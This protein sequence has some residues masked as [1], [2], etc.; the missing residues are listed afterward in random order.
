MNRGRW[1][2]ECPREDCTWAYRATTD[3]GKPHRFLRCT[4]DHLGKGCDLPFAVAW[5]PLDVCLEV[6]RVLFK[7]RQRLTQNWQ[8][9]RE[10]VDAL[11]QENEQLLV[12]WNL[13]RLAEAGIGVAC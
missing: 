11:I 2:V 8:A 5:W 7:R 10:S 3:E 4:G 13:E 6:E 9:G 1:V 12:G